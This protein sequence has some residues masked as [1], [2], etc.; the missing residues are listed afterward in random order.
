MP[1]RSLLLLLAALAAPAAAA[2]AQ[3]PS[4]ADAFLDGKSLAGWDG[5]TNYWKVVDGALVGSTEPGGLKGHNTFLCS[6]KMYGDF[7]LSFQVR[8]KGGRGNS[9]VQIRSEVIDPQKFVVKG[10]QCDMGQQYWG[11]LYGEQFGGMMRASPAAKVKQVVKADDFND[12]SIRCAGKHVT[13]KING[14][15]MVDGDFPKMPDTGIIAFQLHQ[16]PPME[17]TFRKIEFREIK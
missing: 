13:I 15:T 14:E 9:G 6:K 12:Y 4:R 11:S 10:P 1:R 2:L 5:L 3:P 17:V 16:G 8:L 7:E